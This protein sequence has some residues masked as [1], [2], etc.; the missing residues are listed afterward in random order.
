MDRG[1]PPFDE[2]LWPDGTP[3]AAYSAYHQWFAEQDQ[4]HLKRK[5]REAE[6]FFRRT[7]ITFAVYGDEEAEERLDRKSVV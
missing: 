3:R 5:A 7:G 2:M 1:E 4:G 6:E